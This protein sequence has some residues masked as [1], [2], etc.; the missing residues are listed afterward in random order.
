MSPQCCNGPSGRLYLRSRK[1]RC[2]TNILRISSSDQPCLLGKHPQHANTTCSHRAFHLLH[3]G[4]SSHARSVT[5]DGFISLQRAAQTVDE[6]CLEQKVCIVPQAHPCSSRAKA[7]AVEGVTRAYGVKC[8][9]AKLLCS[10]M[11]AWCHAAQE[12]TVVALI[13][14][15]SKCLTTNAFVKRSQTNQAVVFLSPDEPAH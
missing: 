10:V 2:D 9:T 15:D 5:I 7:A 6:L 1:G 12:T 14:N 13:G 3:C 4:L 11:Q 8:S